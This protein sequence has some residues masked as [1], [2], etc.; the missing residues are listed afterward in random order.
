MY[1]VRSRLSRRAKLLMRADFLMASAICV[2]K[3]RAC[4]SCG[5]CG[6]MAA[7]LID[8]GFERYGLLITSS[9]REATISYHDLLCSFDIHVG[10]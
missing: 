9:A 4:S 2:H 7:S 10:L 5:R 6:F 1:S 8:G 3:W